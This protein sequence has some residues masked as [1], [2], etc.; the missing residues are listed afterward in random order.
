MQTFRHFQVLF[1]RLINRVDVLD[2]S[3]VLGL[4]L[5]SG[6]IHDDV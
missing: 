2:S 3:D 1:N 6:Q 5:Y 4:M